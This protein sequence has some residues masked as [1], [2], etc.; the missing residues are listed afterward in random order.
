MNFD[1]SLDRGLAYSE[2]C[3]FIERHI[4][5]QIRKCTHSI[6]TQARSS[7]TSELYAADS[8]CVCFVSGR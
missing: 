4:L 2:A 7:L 5:K 1:V 6:T 3:L 8:L